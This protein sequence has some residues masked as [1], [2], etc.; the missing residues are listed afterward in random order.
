MFHIN[1]VH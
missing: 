1:L